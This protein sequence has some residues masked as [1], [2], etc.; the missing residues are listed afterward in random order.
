[1]NGVTV[2]AYPFRATGPVIL[3][4]LGVL[5]LPAVMMVVLGF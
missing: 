5:E 3:L 2:C 1:M 4:L